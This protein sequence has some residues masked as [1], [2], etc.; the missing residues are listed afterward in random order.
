MP[1]IDVQK[2]KGL[3]RE[4][5]DGMAAEIR[6]LMAQY[7]CSPETSKPAKP[8]PPREEPIRYDPCESLKGLSVGARQDHIDA[9]FTNLAHVLSVQKDGQI[10]INIAEREQEDFKNIEIVL[11]V[12]KSWRGEITKSFE[13]RVVG[14]ERALSALLKQLTRKP[15][16][17]RRV[18]SRVTNTGGHYG[19]R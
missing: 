12:G 9:A 11:R 2:P 7:D 1:K 4:Q 3:S 17:K 6:A 8:P 13:A 19:T 15:R 5:L 16:K 14:K 18:A 10:G